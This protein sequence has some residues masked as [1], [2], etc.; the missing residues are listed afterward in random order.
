MY[1]Y[2]HTAIDID[3]DFKLDID[4][5]IGYHSSKF[6]SYPS[7]LLPGGLGG[8]RL[9]HRVVCHGAA[10]CFASAECFARGEASHPKFWGTEAALLGM[11]NQWST[12]GEC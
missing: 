9:W 4:I 1:I 12:L 3:I 11:S 5:D 2:I 6:P 10:E 8:R 7:C